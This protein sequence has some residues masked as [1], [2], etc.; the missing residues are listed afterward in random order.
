M[1]ESVLCFV[2]SRWN[3]ASLAIQGEVGSYLPAAPALAAITA[4]YFHQ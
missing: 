4:N 2:T 1:Y 3:P